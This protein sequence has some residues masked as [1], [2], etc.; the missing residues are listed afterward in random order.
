MIEGSGCQGFSLT[1]RQIK[2]VYQMLDE[3]TAENR[4]VWNVTGIARHFGVSRPT[5][6]KLIDDRAELAAHIAGR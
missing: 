5:I 2:Q 3:R 1:M 4:P 6:Y